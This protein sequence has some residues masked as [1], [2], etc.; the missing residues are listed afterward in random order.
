MAF[1]SIEITSLVNI[2]V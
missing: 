2:D 1:V